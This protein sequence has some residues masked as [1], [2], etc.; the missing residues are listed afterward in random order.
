MTDPTRPHRVEPEA[1][2]RQLHR[3]R[4]RLLVR[5]NAALEKP[6]IGL[7]IAWLI[8]LIIDLTQ[9]LNPGLLIVH[10]VIWGLF[11]LQFLLGLT[12]APQRV[13]YLRRNWLTAV[14]LM[15]PA[16]RVLRVVQALRALRAARVARLLASGQTARS[17]S[18]VR[19]LSSINRGMRGASTVLGQ[20]GLG[21][22]IAVTLIVIFAGAAGMAYFENPAAIQSTTDPGTASRPEGLRSYGDALWWTAMIMTTLGSEYWPVTPLGRVLAWLLSVYALAVFGYITATIAT[23]FLGPRPEPG[24]A[25]GEIAELR[26]ENAR[27]RAQLESLQ[28]DTPPDPD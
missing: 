6:M 7:A 15:L 23:L 22:M 10:Y 3:E 27:L 19:V 14:S 2:R 8:L 5:I 20:R 25:R 18:M 24:T 4:W 12:I 9:G 21:Y 16:L 11:V 28:R 17:L 13:I 1:A 26:R